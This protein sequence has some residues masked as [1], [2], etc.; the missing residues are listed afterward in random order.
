MSVCPLYRSNRLSVCPLY[1]SN[2]LSVCPLYRSNRQSLCPLY[3]SSRMSVCPLYRS[4]RMSVCP[5]YRSNRLSVCPLY[6][7]N[8]LSVCPLYRSVYSNETDLTV[9][10]CVP[11]TGLLPVME[12]DPLQRLLRQIELQ[13]R[14]ENY[15]WRE[16]WIKH[17][18]QSSVNSGSSILRPS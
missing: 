3:R 2:R 11:Y 14:R 12:K 17:Y 5:L 1:R 9:C 8:R 15:K 6:R 4:N 18:I 16:V 13:T 7:S 10:L